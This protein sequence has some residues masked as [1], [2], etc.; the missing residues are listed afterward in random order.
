MPTATVTYGDINPETAGYVAKKFLERAVPQLVSEQFAQ[1]REHPGNSTLVQVFRR[2]DALNFTPKIVLE[3]ITPDG[4]TFGKTDIQCRLQ[5]LGDWLPTTDIIKDTHTDDVLQEMT[6]ILAE[7]APAMLEM[8]RF[9]VLKAGTNVM[10][11]GGVLSRA[12][13]VAKITRADVRR[14]VRLLDRQ[15][16]RPITQRVRPA[17]EYG[18]EAVAPSYV[19]QCHTDCEGD[20]RDLDGFVTVDKYAKGS[21]YDT[22]IG[23]CERVRFVSAPLNMPFT[24]AGGDKGSMISTTGVKADVYPYL[25]CAANAYATVPFKGQK[26]VTPMVVNPKPSPGDPMGQRGSVAWKTLTGSK[27]LYDPWMVRF[28]AAVTQ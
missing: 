18:T 14:I 19:C 5:Q 21:I 10:Y 3:G 7:Q 13:V 11:A 9:G 22:E 12:T 17:A 16:A 26:A 8:F 6:N 27:I 1:T 20:V 2:Y 28:E 24:D 15:F 4:S 25:F 23:K